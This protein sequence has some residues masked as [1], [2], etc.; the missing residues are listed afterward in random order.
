M[1]KITIIPAYR[2]AIIDGK[3][4][5]GIDMSSLPAEI[6]AVQWDGAKGEIEY[7]VSDDGAKPENKKIDNLDPF[8]QVLAVCAAMDDAQ[9]LPPTLESVKAS[10]I[11]AIASRCR[12]AIEAGFWS[13]ALGDPHLYPAKPQDQANLNASVTASLIPGLP[14]DWTTPFW[15]ADEAGAW[16]YVPHTSAQIQQVGL[17]GKEAITAALL[18]NEQLARQVNDPDTDTPEKVEAIQWNQ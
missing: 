12:A 14:S 5:T 7:R 18:R 3:R 15:C 11:A 8:Q 2:T 6:H 17:D 1:S 4:Y 9:S 10:R 16:S 13:S